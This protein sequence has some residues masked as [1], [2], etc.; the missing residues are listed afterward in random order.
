MGGSSTRLPHDL[1]GP[2]HYFDPA[3]V[4]AALAVLA[5]LLGLV[6]GWWL[7]RKSR[8]NRENRESVG[9]ARQRTQ[10]VAPGGVSSQIQA[11][12]QRFVD[13]Q[14]YRAGC[15][16]LAELLRKHF[17]RR[18]R[19]SL[20]TLTAREIGDRLGQSGVSSLFEL[21]AELQFRRNA[22][23]HDDFVGICDLAS[24]STGAER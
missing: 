10:A 13:R 18:R 7:W 2:L 19:L 6:L 3:W 21:L 4:I 11:L 23:S 8:L 14:N 1:T 20:G 5:G 16:A 24:E 22:P 9:D 17:S 12:K 15:H